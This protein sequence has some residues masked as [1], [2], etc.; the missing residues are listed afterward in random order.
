GALL[1]LPADDFYQMPYSWGYVGTDDFVV[2]MFRRPTIVPNGF[3]YTPASAQLLSA[4]SL[5]SNSILSGD[6]KELEG[7]CAMLGAPLI[8]VRGD[9]IATYPGRTIAPPKQLETRLAV[10]SNASLVHTAGPLSL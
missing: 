4:M 3:G 2:S 7:L 8:L 6:W 10:A 1:V 9:I 5:V